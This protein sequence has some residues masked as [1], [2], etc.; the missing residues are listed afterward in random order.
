M[1]RETGV[2]SVSH[3]VFPDAA[4]RRALASGGRVEAEGWCVRVAV[5][6]GE[7]DEPAREELCR[8]VLGSRGDLPPG[9]AEIPGGY[10]VWM[11]GPEGW[12]SLLDTREGG[13]AYLRAVM[14][15]DLGGIR[16][17]HTVVAKDRS[18][19]GTPWFSVP[20]PA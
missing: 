4:A 6:G 17:C 20:G 8:Y 7:T 18:C 2:I 10:E 14:A 15:E 19:L 12:K 5:S 13:A 11:S 16:A 3:H 1:E 9:I